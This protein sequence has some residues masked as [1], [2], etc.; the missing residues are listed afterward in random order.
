MGEKTEAQKRAQKAYM[1]KFDRVEIRLENKKYEAVKVHIEQ[2][3][4]SM[5]AFINRAI[6]E[7]MERDKDG[8]SNGL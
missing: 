2:K 8:E 3:G 5:N 1:K 7:T 4:E 6:D